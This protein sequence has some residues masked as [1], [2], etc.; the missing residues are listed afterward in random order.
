MLRKNQVNWSEKLENS[1]QSLSSQF[2]KQQFNIQSLLF[3]IFCRYNVPIQS[4]SVQD[5]QS[6]CHYFCPLKINI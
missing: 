6:I 1:K 2:P 5:M 3:P 4:I